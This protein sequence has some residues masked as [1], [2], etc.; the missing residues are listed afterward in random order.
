MRPDYVDFGC[1]SRA[2]WSSDPDMLSAF[3]LPE[4]SLHSLS[5]LKSAP[6]NPVYHHPLSLVSR[7]NNSNHIPALVTIRNFFQIISSLYLLTSCILAATSQP[8]SPLLT[9]L[10]PL[11]TSTI[12]DSSTQSHIRSTKWPGLSFR[13]PFWCSGSGTDPMFRLGNSRTLVNDVGLV[14]VAVDYN[15]E[16]GVK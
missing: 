11:T 14:A 16:F 12:S 6:S 1:L 5:Q 13:R 7:T 15:F 3:E 8:P 4:S 2:C 10:H 9:I